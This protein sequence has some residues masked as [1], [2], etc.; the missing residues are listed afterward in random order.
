MFPQHFT[1]T[2]HLATAQNSQL[3]LDQG[4]TGGFFHTFSFT[5][6]QILPQHCVDL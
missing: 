4:N 2:L 5:S 3:V 1:S 6:V